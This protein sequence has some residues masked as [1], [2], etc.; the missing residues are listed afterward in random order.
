MITMIIRITKFESTT[1]TNIQIHHLNATFMCPRSI[2]G[3]LFDS[4]G[5]FRAT[6]LLRTACI[7][8]ERL[9]G[10]SSVTAIRTSKQII[11]SRKK[12]LL[13]GKGHTQGA[14][15]LPP[16]QT[17]LPIGCGRGSPSKDRPWSQ[18][19]HPNTRTTPLGWETQKRPLPIKHKLLSTYKEPPRRSLNN[20]MATLFDL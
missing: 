17:N 5:R 14:I 16:S 1:G 9:G 3:V 18:A 4:A 11:H 2:P 12:V 15:V 19:F 10:A 7:R 13:L 20:L 6:L 8:S